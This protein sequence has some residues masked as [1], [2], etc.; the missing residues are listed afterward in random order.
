MVDFP[1]YFSG[2]E[3]K[4]RAELE[5]IRAV[6]THAGNKGSKAEQAFRGFLSDHLPRS[7]EVGHGEAFDKHG[8]HAGDR[9]GGDEGVNAP[10]S[11]VARGRGEVADVLLALARIGSREDVGIFRQ[12]STD[13]NA[14]I[15]RAAIEAT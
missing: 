14:T 7:I 6:T 8:N 1:A 2:M 10:G 3:T 4:L 11:L 9:R 12:R 5:S 13:R 15:R